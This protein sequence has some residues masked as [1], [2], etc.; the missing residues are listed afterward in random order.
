M[1]QAGIAQGVFLMRFQ[2][3]LTDVWMAQGWQA[4]GGGWMYGWGRV[5]SVMST[6]I[7][8]CRSMIQPNLFRY[9]DE[10]LVFAIK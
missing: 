8:H 1:K 2:A 5:S 3:I 6:A 9:F 7:E 10:L 4:N